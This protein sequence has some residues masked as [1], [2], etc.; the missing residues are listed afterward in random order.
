MIKSDQVRLSL[1]FVYYIYLQYAVCNVPPVGLK[2]SATFVGKPPIYL[3]I[4]D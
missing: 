4:D 2:A 1:I 3:A